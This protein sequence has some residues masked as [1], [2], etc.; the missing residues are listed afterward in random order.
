MNIIL[1]T[2][3]S[4]MLLSCSLAKASNVTS[5][6]AWKV[7]V[8]SDFSPFSYTDEQ[9]NLTGLHVDIVKAV[10]DSA[11]IKYELSGFPWKRVV[12]LTDQNEVVFSIPWRGKEERFQ[13]YFMAGPLSSSKTVFFEL[14][15]ENIQYQTLSDLKNI[16]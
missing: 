10:M 15:G 9:G 5:S 11:G 8:D 3:L 13:K 16:R 12:Y 6:G 2:L 7:A 14:K 1:K 4:I